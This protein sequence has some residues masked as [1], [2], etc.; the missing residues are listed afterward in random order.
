MSGDG[1][2]DKG[3]DGQRIEDDDYDEDLYERYPNFC[4]RCG[5]C[6]VTLSGGDR[7][8]AGVYLIWDVQ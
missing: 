4:I 8:V 1:G 3:S 7:I 2:S 6:R 5:L